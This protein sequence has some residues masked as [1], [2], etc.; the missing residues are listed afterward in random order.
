MANW[1]DSILKHFQPKVA[2]L[3]LVA[4]PDGLLTEEGMLSAIKDRGFDLIPFED[5]IAFRFA[6]ESQYRSIWDQG[7]PTG[8]VVVLRST[9][10]RL[11]AMPYD[12][13]QASPNRHLKLALHELFP[14]LNYPVIASLDRAYLDAIDE[15]YRKYDGDQM[16]E[17]ETKE[18]VLMHCFGI[19][20]K[21]IKRP[22]DLLKDLLRLHS[23][24]LPLPDPL[25]AYLLDQ[26]KDNKAF[27]NWPLGEIVPNRKALL[28]FLQRE[29]PVFLASLS[30]SGNSSI[31]PFEHEDV[32]VYIDTLFLD[33]ALTPTEAENV[34]QLP[35]WAQ[36]GVRHDPKTD[37]LRRFHLL[38]GRFE[39]D[40][41]GAESSHR[42]WQEAAQR[43]AELVVLRWECDEI[44][45]EDAR[46]AWAELQSKVERTFGQWMVARYGSL[47]NLPYHTQPVMVHQIPRFL[48]VERSRKKLDRIAL[49]VLDGMAF[50]QWIL[51][52]RNFEESQKDW[53]FVESTSFAWVP[54]LTSVTRQS[55]FAAEPPLY[56]PQSLETTSKEKAHWVRF[57]EDQGDKKLSIELVTNISG[58]DD[59]DLLKALGDHRI[60]TLGVVWNKIDNI[61]H[62]M[63]MQTAGMHDQVRLWAIQGHLQRLLDLLHDE[64][65]AVYVTADHGNVTARG[66]GNPR[67]GVLAETK[68]KRVRVYDRPDFLE[69]VATKFPDSIRWP[70]YGLPPARHVLL[71]GDLQAFTTQGEEIVSHGGIALEE[72]MVPFV[73]ITREGV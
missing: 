73:A 10:T 22:V 54:T 52:R 26:L 21:L 68:G 32:R 41:P 12:L 40:L 53:R 34:S 4:D 47:H 42:D 43:W 67:E 69:E 24:K 71:A 33:G 27:E 30:G 72:V 13:L 6:Y 8:L 44:I 31:V 7:L 46:I 35:A 20:P 51:L 50:D 11:E 29:W 5:S 48:A 45:E 56:F 63:Q 1:R 39:E 62:G 16:T 3:T 38:R 9:D 23:R 36:P 58:P 60:K 19:V 49:L 64:G 18:F 15:A 57:W 65:F 59:P 17:K 14:K 2:R 28:E 37:C 70:N 61:M 66:V 55:I 25:S